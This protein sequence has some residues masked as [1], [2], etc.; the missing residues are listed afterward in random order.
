MSEKELGLLIIKPTPAG[1]QDQ[2]KIIIDFTEEKLQGEFGAQGVKRIY[3]GLTGMGGAITRAFY[4]PLEWP[5]KTEMLDWFKEQRVL[6]PFIFYGNY[7]LA[8]YLKKI[9]GHKDR[10]TNPDTIR[11]FTRHQLGAPEKEYMNFVHAPDPERVRVE[12]KILRDFGVIPNSRKTWSKDIGI[13]KGGEL[14]T[15]LQ[16]YELIYRPGEYNEP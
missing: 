14:E 2:T 11:G 16:E 10:E 5:G 13:S 7:G 3:N 6:H 4:E 15:T 9:T 1:N 12:L 8:E